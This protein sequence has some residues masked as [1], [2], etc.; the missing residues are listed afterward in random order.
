MEMHIFQIHGMEMKIMDNMD[1]IMEKIL[2][3]IQMEI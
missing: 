3:I 2:Y 1:I